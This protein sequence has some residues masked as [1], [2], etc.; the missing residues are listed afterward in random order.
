MEII[1]AL[2]VILFCLFTLVIVMGF[3]IG[4]ST[5]K[6]EVHDEY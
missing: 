1:R 4:D 6:R 5:Q 2:A 3:E